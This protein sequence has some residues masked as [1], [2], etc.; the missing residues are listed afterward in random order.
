M[1]GHW[2]PIVLLAKARKWD[3]SIAFAGAAVAASG[4]ILLSLLLGLGA[5]FIGGKLI[6]LDESTTDLYSAYGLI[7]FGL[8]YALQA[9]F[10]HSKCHGHTHHGPNP[11]HVKVPLLFL[12]SLG[13]A[14]CAAAIPV[15]GAAAAHSMSAFIGSLI[16]FSL[17][18]LGAF[19]LATLTALQGILRF[20]HPLLEHYGDTITGCSVALMGGFLILFEWLS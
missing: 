6:T 3:R 20:D 11:E 19:I 2:L 14:P 4:H 1:P 15:F 8:L 18:V 7:I 9:Y 10:R 5:I 13:L 12:F 17:G 16:A